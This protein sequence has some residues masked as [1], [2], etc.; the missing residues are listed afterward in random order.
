MAEK[1][2]LGNPWLSDFTKEGCN[3]PSKAQEV[4]LSTM[5]AHNTL[6]T[7]DIKVIKAKNTD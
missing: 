4:K 6:F 5:Q 7:P 1:R 2:Y 3:S